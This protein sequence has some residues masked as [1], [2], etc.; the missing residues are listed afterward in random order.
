MLITTIYLSVLSVWMIISPRTIF[1]LC[2]VAMLSIK[3]AL[4]SGYRLTG[5]IVLLVEQRYVQENLFYNAYLSH[6]CFPSRL[7]RDWHRQLHILI[8][9]I[10]KS[11]FFCHFVSRTKKPPS[12]ILAIRFHSPFYN[13]FVT[14]DPCFGSMFC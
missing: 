7:G 11:V 13:S 14:S 10:K 4:M 3:L 9:Y 6:D 8:S 1:M 5:I 2:R 12:G